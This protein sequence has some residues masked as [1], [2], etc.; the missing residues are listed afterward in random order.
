M[1]TLPDTDKALQLAS[2]NSLSTQQPKAQVVRQQ[3]TRLTPWAE[4]AQSTTDLAYLLHHKGPIAAELTQPE[5]DEAITPENFASRTTRSIVLDAPVILNPLAIAKP[6]GQEIWFSG[7]EERGESTVTQG[8]TTLTLSAYLALAP[9]RTVRRAPPLLLKILDPNPSPETGCL[10]FETHNTKH[11]VYVV[12]HID[13]GAW[14]NGEGA[15]R[16]GMDQ[17]RRKS[18]SDDQEFRSAYLQ[19]VQQYEEVRRKIDAGESLHNEEQARRANMEA[20]T[21]LQPLLVGDVVQVTPN[22]PH[23]LQNGVRVFEFQTPTYERNI[24]SFNQRVL[25]QDHWDS[26]YAVANMSLDRPASPA[27]EV[28]KK[29]QHELIERIVDFEDFEVVRITLASTHSID[30][31]LTNG[32]VMLAMLEGELS[33]ECSAASVN[34]AANAEQRAALVP[35]SAKQARFTASANGA[36]LIIARPKAHTADKIPTE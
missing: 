10:Y 16:L 22:V 3:I 35:A 19:A 2:S 15:I 33:I 14:P 6:W 26:K 12:T 8:D 21:A 20:F 1:L 7:I 4:Q 18:Y 27:I 28:L 31:D 17:S 36:T 24:I 23:S 5:R 13:P 25:T 32:Y 9:A 34:L 29:T 30:A 11:E